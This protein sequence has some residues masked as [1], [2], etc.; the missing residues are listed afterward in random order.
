[1]IG[2]IVVSHGYFASE[3]LKSAEMIMGPQKKV[4]VIPVVPGMDLDETISR[5]REAIDEIKGDAGVIVMTD[6]IG[7]TPSN[8]SGILTAT[9]EN[10]LAISGFNLPMLLEILLLRNKSLDEI[11]NSIC[12]IGRQNIINL[13]EKVKSSL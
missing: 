13:T 10:M 12:E 3:A 5:L 1:M 4:K 11:S 6:I 8:A 2:V 7:G 9:T